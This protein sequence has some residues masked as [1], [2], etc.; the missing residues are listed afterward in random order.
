MRYWSGALALLTVLIATDTSQD[1]AWG[2]SIT[3]AVTIVDPS[4]H[5]VPHPVSRC[6]SSTEPA[7]GVQVDGTALTGHRI[8]P[9]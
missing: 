3:D 4:R 5:P 8:S 7:P 1:L 6:L 2:L 9:A